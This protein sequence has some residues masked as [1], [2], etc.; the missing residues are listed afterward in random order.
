MSWMLP[1]VALLGG[2]QIGAQ[3]GVID[4]R[5]IDRDGAVLPG[6]TVVVSSSALQ[7]PRTVV[8]DGRGAFRL[9][10]LPAGTYDVVL[11]LPAFKTL[12]GQVAVRADQRAVVGFHLDVGARE[13]VINVRGVGVAPAPAAVRPAQPAVVPI[14]VGG[15]VREPRRLTYVEPVYPAAALA[16]G[17]EGRVVIEA[18]IGRDGMVSRAQIVQGVPLLDEAA[19]AAVQQ[20]RYSAT[21]L[22]GVPI[23]VVMHVTIS[24]VR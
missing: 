10:G 12:R 2:L 1:V 19:L 21:M 8:S 4:G 3:G 18:V 16:A 9:T 15:A 22:N 5:A 23:E 13:E 20:W 6:V 14:R 7:T 17:V 24:F 11:T